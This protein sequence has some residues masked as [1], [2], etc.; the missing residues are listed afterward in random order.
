MK[1]PVQLGFSGGLLL[2]LGCATADPYATLPKSGDP[3]RDGQ[4]Y[5]NQGPAKDK[6]LWQYRTALAY[7]RRGEGAA[8]KPLL[9]DALLT[10]GGIV[11]NDKNAK[12]ARG[13]FPE[14]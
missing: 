3:I 4:A 14:E 13:Y 8:A 9:D 11:A 6:V 1:A 5:I 7:L 2:L 12:K 10:I